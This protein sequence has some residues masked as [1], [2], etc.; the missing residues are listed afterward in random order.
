[1]WITF[2]VWE[3][4]TVKRA[5]PNQHS[6]QHLQRPLV[7]APPSDRSIKMRTS[8]I[9]ASVTLVTATLALRE[10]RN[11]KSTSSKYLQP[12]LPAITSA[13]QASQPRQELCRPASLAATNTSYPTTARAS[14]SI[15]SASN[16][17]AARKNVVTS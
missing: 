8:S 13:H 3:P 16:N 12:T 14:P 9:L 6:L 15:P 17:L 2:I 7:H 11:C 1:V 5:L 10:H 4:P